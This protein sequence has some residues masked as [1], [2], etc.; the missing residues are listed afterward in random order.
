MNCSYLKRVSLASL[1]SS[2]HF[3]LL[4]FIYI[5]Q[6]TYKIETG[7]GDLSSN[8]FLQQFH[9]FIFLFFYQQFQKLNYLGHMTDMFCLLAIGVAFAKFDQNR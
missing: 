8:A 6:N 5:T 1:V 2:T 7:R 9:T 3:R 4:I